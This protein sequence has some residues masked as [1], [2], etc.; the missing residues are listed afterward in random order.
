MGRTAD[1]RSTVI[2]N[3][4][5]EIVHWKRNLFKV[6][7]GRHGK[8]FVVELARLFQAYAD[9]S[10]LETVALKAAMIL[11]SLILQKPFQTSKSKDHVAC[12]ERRL[13]LWWEG[14]FEALV[15]EGRTIQSRLSRSQSRRCEG[16]IARRFGDLMMKGKLRE[17]TRL[18]SDESGKVL[19]LDSYVEDNKC[20]RDV[21]R[22]KHPDA[23]PLDPS[24]IASPVDDTF[25]P[26][27]FEE[28]TGSTILN[29]ALHTEGSAGPSGL[30][31][32][33]W[34]RLC[35]SFQKVSTDLCEALA[36]VARRLATSLVDPELLKPFVACR[37][38][39]LDKCPGVRPV[40]IGE[41]PRRIISKAIL[42]VVRQDVKKAV[43]SI[44]LCIGQSQ[45]C[46]ASIQA[47]NEIFAEDSTEAVLLVDASNAFNRLTRKSAL[48][49]AMN[50]CP[51]IGTILMNTYRLDP[52]LFIN[53]ETMLS[54]EGTTQGDP[55]AMAMYAVATIPLIKQL[56]VSNDIEQV[57]FADDSAAGGKIQ[58]LH[59]WW[60]KLLRMGPGYGYHANAMKTWLLVKE[61][62]YEE[63]KKT[64]S[65]TNIQITTTGRSYLGSTIG[66]E[67]FKTAFVKAKVAEWTK[68]LTKLA[69]IATSQPH[70]AYCALTRCIKHKWSYLSRTTHDI[71]VL[72]QPVEDIIRHKVI[73]A[74]VGKGNINDSERKLFALPPKLGGLGI[75]ILP[76]LAD[77]LYQASSIISQPLKDAIRLRS[78]E[79]GMRTDME[80]EKARRE[81][82]KMK[83]QQQKRMADELYED[84]PADLRKAMTLA[85][86]K[87]ASSW[88]TPLPIEEHGFELHKSAF[89]DAIALRYGWRPQGM[90][91]TCICGKPNDVSHAFSCPTG[92]YVILRHN[93]IRDAT[94]SM[95]KEVTS[96][97]ETEPMLQPLTGEQLNYHSA[98]TE[99]NCRL[100]IKC[101]G[102][103][104]A[105]QDAFFDVR[106]FNPM[107]SSNQTS[108]INT[109][110]KSHEKEKKRGYDQRI[111]EVE[112]GSFTPLVMSITG[113]MGPAATVFYRRLAGMIADKRNQ[114]YSQTIS[115]LRCR[116]RFCLLRSSIRAI[117]GS[118]S[119]YR[120]SQATIDC[121]PLIM[122]EG[123]VPSDI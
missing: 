3:T 22:D 108:D 28:I 58:N 29:A 111:R 20:V 44:Q 84:L 106:V 71:G 121:A 19:Q 63:A 105:S 5:D 11:P 38:V 61:E 73:P 85:K 109:I 40:G 80:Q 14:K 21:L 59:G 46:E 1:R 32:Y 112:Y 2:N 65:T 9:Q 114:P 33:A 92:G 81:M 82:R 83:R 43:G 75:D 45:G 67:D 52:Y 57:W 104:S 31:S 74:I 41:V 6:P 100:D 49:N 25:H 36:K 72:L 17:A 35:G 27:I 79:D 101:S 15:K 93:E 56:N 122:A 102:F 68:E 66:E 110:Y 120:C 51:A 39:A 23:H 88:L 107:A 99:D 16:N 91:S 119:S 78:F 26:V 117:R 115:L 90:P 95:L 123:R 76:Q 37:L 98:K 60:E 12:V 34:R 10:A 53:G 24:T 18:L 47:L 8:S 77:Q 96:S 113:G 86:E 42:A 70:A 116:I 64:F 118:R 30:D 50:L 97:V 54:K 69:D 48:R 4:Y 55:L 62:A 87:G 13:K 7:S 103:W 89:R 94:A